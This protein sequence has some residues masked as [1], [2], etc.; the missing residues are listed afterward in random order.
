MFLGKEK[1]L[2]TKLSQAISRTTG[3]NIELVCTHF[4]EFPMLIPNM[5]TIFN[6]S[7]KK[8]VKME[9]I[10]IDKYIKNVKTLCLWSSNIQ[11]LS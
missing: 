10:A 3:S 8:V 5:G 7:G 1:N 2:F 6:N 9:S 11:T 4:D